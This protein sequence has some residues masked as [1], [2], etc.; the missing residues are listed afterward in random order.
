[1]EVPRRNGND[2]SNHRLN[3][4]NH[5]FHPAYRD[6]TPANISHTN[7]KIPAKNNFNQQHQHGWVDLNSD[8]SRTIIRKNKSGYIASKCTS[9]VCKSKL[10][11][12]GSNFQVGIVHKNLNIR[13]QRLCHSFPLYPE[14]EPLKYFPK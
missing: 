3:N 7:T 1:M 8:N 6:Q 10:S 11:R 14:H 2:N 4:L 5:Y 13:A 12:V 9:R